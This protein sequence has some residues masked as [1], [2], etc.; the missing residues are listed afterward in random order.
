VAARHA[1]P[2]DAWSARA[3]ATQPADLEAPIDAAAPPGSV[4]LL[5]RAC[6]RD[7]RGRAPDTAELAAWSVGRR[8]DGLVAIRLAEGRPLERIGLACGHEGCGACFEAELDL[9]ACRRAQDETPLGIAAAGGTLR[10]RLPTGADHTRWLSERTSLRSAAACL[11]E[12]AEPDEATIEAL[13]RALAER[14]PLR[15]LALDLACPECGARHQHVLN[16]EAH[17]L[18]AFARAQERWLAE[19]GTLARAFHWREADIAAMPAWRRA[20]YLERLEQAGA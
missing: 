16:L 11:L 4:D 10:A 6:L 12:G 1:P 3:F 2:Q 17:L 5:L 14:D 7:S 13:D 19:I 18:R 15:E 20:F 8:L 9:A